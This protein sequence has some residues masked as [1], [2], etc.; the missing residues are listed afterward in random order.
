MA[1]SVASISTTA[2][3]VLNSPFGDSDANESSVSRCC[4][5]C[6]KYTELTDEG[7]QNLGLKKELNAST[8]AGFQ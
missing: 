7:M 1:V 5:I 2:L 8:T 4:S 6:T 3:E